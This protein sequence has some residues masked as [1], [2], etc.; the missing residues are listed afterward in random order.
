MPAWPVATFMRKDRSMMALR[1]STTV[2]SRASRL[3]DPA[4]SSSVVWG[5]DE[6]VG[7]T[8]RAAQGHRIAVAATSA[9]LVEIIQRSKREE[10]A[11][12]ERTVPRGTKDD[13]ST[14]HEGIGSPSTTRRSNSA[15]MAP[16]S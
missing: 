3:N 14:V 8:V 2:K 16:I 11:L 6:R 9:D 15:A 10:P 7:L 1:Q 5:K 12:I 13:G 4:I